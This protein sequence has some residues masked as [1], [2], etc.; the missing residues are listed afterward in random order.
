MYPLIECIFAQ[1]GVKL[2]HILSKSTSKLGVFAPFR[3]K[4]PSNQAF[5]NIKIKKPN[6]KI[7][8]FVA[9]TGDLG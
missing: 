5:P 3:V 2:P 4:L 8:K 9:K 6:I 1:N 7:K